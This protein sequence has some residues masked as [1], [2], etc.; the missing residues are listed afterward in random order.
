MCS[1]RPPRND[2]RHNNFEKALRKHCLSSSLICER[3]VLFGVFSPGGEGSFMCVSNSLLSPASPDPSLLLRLPLASKT[4]HDEV[5]VDTVE[6]RH[7]R[8]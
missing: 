6:A 3:G 5:L 2:L 7:R 8:L 4:H 1:P